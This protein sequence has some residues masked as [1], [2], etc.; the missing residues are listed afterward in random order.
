M[1]RPVVAALALLALVAGACVGDSNVTSSGK[2]LPDVTVEFPEQVAPG[3]IATATFRIT[4]PGPGDMVGL[5]ITFARVGNNT[6]IVDGGAKSK[7]PAIDAIDPEPLAVD[8]A[9]VVYRFPGLEEGES[10]SIS[11][12]LVIPS[13]TGVVANSVTVSAA[14]DQERLFGLRLETTVG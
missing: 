11:F 13:T 14:E 6:P 1:I 7:N 12:D 2:G 4:N 10:T 9:G 5:A 3:D 8:L